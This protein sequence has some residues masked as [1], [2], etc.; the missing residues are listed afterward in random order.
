MQAGLGVCVAF[1]MAY[2]LSLAR[3]A[4]CVFLLW[5]FDH[6]VKL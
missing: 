6:L 3:N 2:A 5:V 1:F 4:L